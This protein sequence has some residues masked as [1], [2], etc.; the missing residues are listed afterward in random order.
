MLSDIEFCKTNGIKGIVTGVLRNDGTVDKTA[1]KSLINA[2]GNMQLTFHRAIDIALDPLQALEDIIDCGFHRILTSGQKETAPEGAELIA[3]L[4]KQAAGRIIIMPGSGVNETNIAKLH[5]KSNCQEYH[6]S[7]K[8]KMNQS[9]AKP[10][11]SDSNQT[12]TVSEVK[13]KKMLDV[14]KSC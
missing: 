10:L 7:A 14:L 1:N 5:Q 9:F 4:N 2:A 11:P 6:S 3:E 12:W 8:I 13:I